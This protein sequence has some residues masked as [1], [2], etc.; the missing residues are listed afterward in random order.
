M[1]IYFKSWEMAGSE[2]GAAGAGAELSIVGS[3]LICKNPA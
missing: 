2:A 1:E 3:A